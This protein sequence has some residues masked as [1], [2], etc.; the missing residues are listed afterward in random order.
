MVG[1]GSLAPGRVTIF[2]RVYG[3][4]ACLPILGTIPMSTIEP[5]DP[6]AHAEGSSVLPPDV[7]DVH[8]RLE[9]ATARLAIAGARDLQ[10][11]LVQARGQASETAEAIE[12]LNQVQDATSN[13]AQ[14]SDRVS[15]RARQT[16]EAAVAGAEA[17][18]AIQSATSGT[19]GAVTQT[20]TDVERLLE[21]AARIEQVVKVIGRIAFDTNLLALNA[22]I[23]AA[24]AG[25]HGRG[26]AVLAQEIRKLSESTAREAR[27]ITGFVHEVRDRA[28]RVGELVGES[29]TWAAAAA[30]EGERGHTAVDRIG[31]LMT[32]T[33]AEVEEIAA[34][35]DQLVRTIQTVDSRLRQVGERARETVSRAEAA[36]GSE[37]VHGAT[38]EM[39][40]L[41]TRHQT[42]GTVE[43]M[44]ELARAAGAEAEAILARLVDGGTVRLE[45][46]LDWR[47]TEARG[48]LIQHLARLFDVR[49]VPET[50]F[51]P[52][53]Y[54]TSWDHL[55]DKPIREL[56]DRILASD[57]RVVNAV[58]PDLNGYHYTHL[59]RH[60]QDWTGDAGADTTG[61]RVKRIFD[62]HVEIR[63]A[64]VGLPNALQA[65]R[66]ASR[67]QFLA[68]GVDP[69]ALDGEAPFLL[70]T[71]ARDTGEVI[72]DLAVPLFV[73]G[74]RFGAF[75]IAFSMENQAGDKKRPRH[76]RLVSR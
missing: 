65:P 23:E 20:E 25:Q 71:Y 14:A 43:Q 56:C 52:P 6:G 64:R 72:H 8:R 24:R 74:R 12:L 68:A 44:V 10:A 17:L 29:K 9:A 5:F 47:Y 16:A 67:D 60:C 19:L 37:S 13:A 2:L 49:R 42:G 66:R 4:G 54:Q 30:A 33:A 41:L 40:W 26:F 63:R 59:S 18:T 34:T 22:S 57:P 36:F 69:D 7:L 39:F 35:N 46:L 53:K 73:K 62:N 58:A 45:Q 50:G 15:E 11:L 70:Q 55:I 38:E 75:A 27:Q 1:A 61:N 48:R 28:G 31:S 3:C 32:D 21:A 76:L 51:D